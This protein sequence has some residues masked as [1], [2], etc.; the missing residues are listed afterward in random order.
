MIQNRLDS[1]DNQ[2][3]LGLESYLI[4]F[5]KLYNNKK[6]P[7]VMMLSGLKGI[8]KYTLTTHLMNYI[9]DKSNYDI[10]KLEISNT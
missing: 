7:K 4:N 5:I 10:N 1:T 9:F 6:L 3:L 8:G 2:R